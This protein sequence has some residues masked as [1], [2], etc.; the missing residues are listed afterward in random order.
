MNRSMFFIFVTI[1][2]LLSAYRFGIPMQ[3]SEISIPK[4][5]PKPVYDVSSEAI[6]EDGFQLGRSLFYDPILSRDSTISCATC[7]LQ[8]TGFAHVDHNVSHGIYG[9]KG[10][11]NAPAL[12]NLAW[13][14]FFHWDG[15]VNHIEAQGINPLT[16]PAEMDNT[17]PEVL[18][19]L[20]ANEDYRKRFQQVYGSSE[21][22]TAKL[23][24]AL[25]Q[26]TRSL[27][28]SN[29]KYDLVQ[30]KE[31][32]VTFSEQE[33]SG[34]NLFRQHCASCHQEPLFTSHQFKSNGLAR[35][36]LFNDLGRFAITG[37]DADSFLFMVPTLR[38]IEFT[39]PYMH[40]GRFRKLKEVIVHYSEKIDSENSHLSHELKGPIHLSDKEQKDL[41]AFLYTLTDKQF[42]YN[43]RFSFPK[44]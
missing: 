1:S 27:I 4:K 21:I 5:W 3:Q 25:S 39:F 19:R 17:L 15:G 33:Q 23:M 37:K 44:K 10:T 24:N 34:L 18:R 29:S 7:H 22:S 26:F 2:V 41:L 32:G 38:N 14:K 13:K 6:S 8:Y 28:S 43:P 42:L 20:M 11:R 9:R 30:R 16:H 31:K 36:P 40:D 12:I 35:D